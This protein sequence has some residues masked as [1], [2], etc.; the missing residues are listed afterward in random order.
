MSTQDK[1]KLRLLG[2]LFGA[3][4][5]IASLAFVALE[6][7]QN[8]EA[9]KS[10]TINALSEQGYNAAALFIQD[11]DLT[12]AFRVIRE[13][14]EVSA[15][16]HSKVNVFY[17]TVLRIQK[18]RFLQIRLGFLDVE[19]ALF[20]GGSSQLYREPH[21]AEY[22]DEVKGDEPEDFVEYM[23]IHVMQRTGGSE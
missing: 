2:Q 20:I 1:S 18:N 14:E 3:L 9:V 16:Q 7:R 19:T 11:D 13:G 12:E 10:A 6:I 15:L 4:G 5:V 8:T 17:A 21:F 23:E 22:W